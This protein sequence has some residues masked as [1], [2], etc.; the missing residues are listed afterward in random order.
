MRLLF[1]SILVPVV[2]LAIAGFVSAD[3]AVA[4]DSTPTARDAEFAR[5]TAQLRDA[6]KSRL[7]A[8]PSQ[9]AGSC[10]LK[11][12]GA[13]AFEA[14]ENVEL[15]LVRLRKQQDA[16]W[17]ARGWSAREAAAA[18]QPVVLNGSGYNLK[19]TSNR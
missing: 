11:G 7:P 15:H 17:K 18:G 2:T 12:T 1:S 5:W 9:E 13:A 6:Q 8:A 3:Q 10:A 19:T 4:P 14:L 16:K